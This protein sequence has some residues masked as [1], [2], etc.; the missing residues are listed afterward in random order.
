MTPD[1]PETREELAERIAQPLP[2]TQEFSLRDRI[3]M[4]RDALKPSKPAK[5]MRRLSERFLRTH[6]VVC[7]PSKPVDGEEP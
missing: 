1:T 6:G 2:P 5:S 7:G 4:A 3:A